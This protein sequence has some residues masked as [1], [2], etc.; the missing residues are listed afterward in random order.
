MPSTIEERSNPPTGPATQEVAGDK[1]QEPVLCNH[2]G[3]TASNGISCE[4]ICVAD[5]GY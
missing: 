4:G 2:C 5:S 3:R 1:K